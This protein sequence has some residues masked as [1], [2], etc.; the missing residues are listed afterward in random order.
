MNEWCIYIALFVYCCT[1]KALYNHVGGLSSTTTSVQHPLGWCDGCHR[2]TAPVRSP[3]TSYRWR[4]ERE[5][6]PIKWMG[7]IRRPWLTRASGG[8]LART[9]GLHPTLYE[10]CHGIFN[11]HRESGPRFNVGSERRMSYSSR[12]PH[13]VPLLSAKNRKRRLQFTQASPK[14]DNRRLEK[15]CLV[16]GVSIS[17]ARFRC[18]VRIWRKEHESM[19][20]SCL[21]SAVQAGG[22]GGVMVWVGM[23]R[24]TGFTINRALKCH[25]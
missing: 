22:G 1:P 17:A 3:H 8:N 9:P 23:Q 20:P 5:I 6:E 4:G 10:K 21:E 11:D 18:R 13:R 24:L 2:T 7:I 12:R 19:D 15:R 16:W 25:G 14:L